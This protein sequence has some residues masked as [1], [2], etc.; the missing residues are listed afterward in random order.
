MQ[1]AKKPQDA[2]IMPLMNYH[3]DLIFFF[4]FIFRFN[5]RF[6]CIFVVRHRRRS[7]RRHNY[8]EFGTIRPITERM[9]IRLRV[10][11]C[12]GAVRAYIVV[13]QCHTT[14]ATVDCV[15]SNWQESRSTGMD[16]PPS[17]HI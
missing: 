4:L 1:V 17:L 13:M 3:A 12:G 2:F 14:V 16:A 8:Y 5:I 9:R 6:E 7:R 15:G 11:M 10:E